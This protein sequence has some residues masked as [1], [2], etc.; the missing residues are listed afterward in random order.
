[1]SHDTK[2]WCKVRRKTDLLNFKNN[3]NLV[4]FGLSTQNSRNFHFGWF[5]LCKV[6]NVRPEKR[7]RSYLSWHWRVMQN[8]N[9][10]LTCGFKN[11]MRNMTNFHWS[12]WKISKLGFWWDPFIQNR[13]RMSL[14]FTEKLCVMRMKN[15]AKLDEELNW[16]D[17][18]FEL[19]K[20][21][22]VMF[23]R[24]EDWC[25]IWR[26]TG[27]CFL[28]WPEELGKFLPEHLKNLKIGTLIGSFDPK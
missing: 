11:D 19:K 12:T 28:K 8:L 7:Q 23:G 27:L 17:I 21:R 10:K 5:L 24:T 14:K 25:K 18:M 9:K 22:G 13:K 6:Y 16:I 2:D 20:Y 1:M 4:S 3:K 26:K 15:D